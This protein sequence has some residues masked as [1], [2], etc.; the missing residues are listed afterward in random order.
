MAGGAAG[1]WERDAEAWDSG[2][3]LDFSPSHNYQVVGE[4]RR[5]L[6]IILLFLSLLSLPPFLPYCPFIFYYG[7]PPCNRFIFWSSF[8]SVCYVKWHRRCSFSC[9]K[10]D[11]RGVFRSRL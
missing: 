7:N 5:R 9:R 2:V 8:L 11:W 1:Q 4:R 3:S 10:E 6:S